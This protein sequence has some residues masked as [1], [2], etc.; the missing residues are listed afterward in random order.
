MFKSTVAILSALVI[1]P[2]ANAAELI[3]ASHANLWNSLGQVGV[4]TFLN[5]PE[6]CKG[7]VDGLYTWNDKGESA[8]V[9][10]Q[11]NATSRTEVLWTAN[12]LDT[13]R[14]ESW[15]LVQDCLSDEMSDGKLSILSDDSEYDEALVG[16]AVAILGE[17]RVS[18]IIEG[19][20][21]RGLDNEEILK[22]IE[23]FLIADTT[24]PDIIASR[25]V[26]TCGV[27]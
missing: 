12:D 25:V 13:L 1:A 10:C 23:A 21:G 6:V 5:E 2:V 9:I 3:P 4:Y 24:H 7:S 16:S 14:H 26:N 8:M 19:Y 17:E 18:S 15:H 27:R 20:R 11:D 22:E